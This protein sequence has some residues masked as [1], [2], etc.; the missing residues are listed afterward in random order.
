VLGLFGGADDHIPQEQIDEF[1]AALA[2]AG[3]EHELISYPGAPHSFFDRSF[4]EHAEACEDAWRRVLGFLDD[5]G[6]R[7]A[8]ATPAR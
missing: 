8:G 3:V 4:D 2:D 1:D 5:V 7:T 6:A